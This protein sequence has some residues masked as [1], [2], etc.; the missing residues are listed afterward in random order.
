MIGRDKRSA[1]GLLIWIRHHRI[2]SGII[3]V[4][5]AFLVV[6]VVATALSTPATTSTTE[7]SVR[8]LSPGTTPSADAPSSS[9]TRTPRTKPSPT[10]KPSPKPTSKPKPTLKPAVAYD[11]ISVVDGDTVH[12]SKDGDTSVRIIGIDTPETVDPNSPVQCFGPEAST[13]AHE[14]LDGTRVRL[15]SDPTQDSVDRYGRMLAYVILSDGRDFGQIMI[16]EGY[17]HEYTYAVAYQRQ[18][19]YQRA[20]TRAQANDAGL[21]S[22]ATCDGVT[23]EALTVPTAAPTA[24]V[25]PDDVLYENCSDAEAAGVTPL[26]PGDPGYNF[27]LDRDRDGVACES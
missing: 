16:T 1:R 18:A 9:S 8:P 25:G 26:H 24:S 13:R 17:A 22:S 19:A 20:Q 6:A 12:V 23:D 5:F 3:A 27:D 15:V 2:L 10:A 14:L 4:P 7:G 21:W 11:V